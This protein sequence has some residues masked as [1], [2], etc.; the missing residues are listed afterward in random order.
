MAQEQLA[1]YASE[2]AAAATAVLQQAEQLDAT[3]A[4][5]LSQAAAAGGGSGDAAAPAAAALA[6][7]K[8]R[9]AEAALEAQAFSEQQ[10]ADVERS[11]RSSR[12]VR[13]CLC[14]HVGVGGARAWGWLA[15]SVAV[16]SVC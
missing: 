5:L 6:S 8:A 2:K 10:A 15:L 11:K 16:V 3:L 7:L 13:V 1:E 14:V 9:L 4:Q 12:Q